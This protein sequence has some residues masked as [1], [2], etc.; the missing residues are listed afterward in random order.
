MR[1]VDLVVS[2]IDLDKTINKGFKPIENAGLD[3][4]YELFSMF[5]FEEAANVLLQGVFGEVFSENVERYCYEKES[6]EDFI[7][8]LLNCKSDLKDEANVD[9]KI[10]VLAVLLDIERERYLTC[11]EFADLGVIFDIPTVMD[12][13]HDFIVGLANCNVG[14]AIYAYSDGEISKLEVLDFIFDKWE[15]ENE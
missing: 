13:I 12:C 5:D 8:H 9:E 10:K 15:Q 7:A 4:I 2:I 1:K 3:G 14:D 11:L 6:K